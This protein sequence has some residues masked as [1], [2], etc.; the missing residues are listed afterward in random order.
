MAEALFPPV[1][2]TGQRGAT[3]STKSELTR[4]RESP[5]PHNLERTTLLIGK[6]KKKKFKE[7]ET[8]TFLFQGKGSSARQQGKD[9]GSF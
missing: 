9:V 5:P 2:L 8:Q 3:R 7:M 6:V 1:G 4:R